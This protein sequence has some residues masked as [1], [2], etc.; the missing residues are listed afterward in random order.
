MLVWQTER[1][2]IGNVSCFICHGSFRIQSRII[3]VVFCKL[4]L[5]VLSIV[6][7]D[8]SSLI[9]DYALWFFEVNVNTKSAQI[10]GQILGKLLR[11][12]FLWLMLVQ[13]RE[14]PNFTEWHQDYFY[15]TKF[16]NCLFKLLERFSYCFSIV[17]TQLQYRNIIRS[18]F[19]V[20]RLYFSK[21]LKHASS[22]FIDND[23][24]ILFGT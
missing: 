12:H 10:E 16:V 11:L 2:N 13:F 22:H 8:N 4:V 24:F 6:H 23:N 1:V 9:T 3:F 18:V 7:L 15:D 19:F 17:W 14:L 20:N 21:F 5:F